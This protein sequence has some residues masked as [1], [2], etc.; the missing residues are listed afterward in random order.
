MKLRY[1]LEGY[2]R[3]VDEFF[4]DQW[5]DRTRHVRTAGNVSL[6]DAGITQ[7]GD[8][9]FHMP[10]RPWQV[11]RALAAAPVA[12][13][14]EYTYV[15]LGS[16][17]GRSLFVAAEL[18]FREVIGVEFSRTL[19]ERAAAN[20]RSFR[21]RGRRCGPVRSVHA[22]A[23][24]FAFPQTPLVV[25][26]FNPFGATTTQRVLDNLEASL[27]TPPAARRRRVA[28]ARLRRPGGPRGRHAA[29]RPRAPDPMAA[30][31][32]GLSAGRSGRRRPALKTDAG[33]AFFDSDRKGRGRRG[34]RSLRAGAEAGPLL[35]ESP[36]AAARSGPSDTG[37]GFRA[38]FKTTGLPLRS[39]FR[40]RRVALPSRRPRRLDGV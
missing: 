7:E 36:S 1:R 34:R 29:G 27:P 26:L 5:F 13:A 20:V 16:G 40:V 6:R 2:G 33:T 19:H 15:D 11:R 12:T 10:A 4:Q 30:D 23:T 21:H 17:K 39:A 8:S 9:R 24:D 31:V 14:S 35:R 37:T 32:R 3:A 25:Y 28:L 22:D 38:G 18:P